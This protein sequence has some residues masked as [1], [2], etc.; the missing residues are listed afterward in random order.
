[1]K[2]GIHPKWY[3]EAKVTC[4]CGASFTVGSTK[5]EIHVEICANCHPFFTGEIKYV[6]TAGRVEKFQE[7]QKKASPQSL[8]KKK[9]KKILKKMEKEKEEEDRPKTLKEMLQKGLRNKK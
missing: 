6:D 9:Q 2:D 4:S 8:I 5:P 3:P 7:K 1:M